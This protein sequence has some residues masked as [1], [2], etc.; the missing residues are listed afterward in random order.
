M[1]LITTHETEAQSYREVRMQRSEEIGEVAEA[2]AHELHMQ[3]HTLPA[4]ERRH[5]YALATRAVSTLQGK[6]LAEELADLKG[7]CE[8]ANEER[9]KANEERDKANEERDKVNEER[10]KV[11][12]ERDKANE[13]RDKTQALHSQALAK[14][15]ETLRGIHEAIEGL[16]VLQKE[17]LAD[18][19]AACLADVIARLREV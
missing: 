12:E 18:V 13:E 6:L 2:L 17:H 10:D 19:H 3:L 16:L 14:L 4:D 11:N 7:A 9:D 1:Q 5:V 8:E 15:V